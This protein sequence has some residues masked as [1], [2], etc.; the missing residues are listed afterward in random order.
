MLVTVRDQRGERV[1]RMRWLYHRDFVGLWRKTQELLQTISKFDDIIHKCQLH[2]STVWL[3]YLSHD[4]GT[5]TADS[6]GG[7]L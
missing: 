3:H 2:F 7:L 1:D 5:G 4:V 6:L